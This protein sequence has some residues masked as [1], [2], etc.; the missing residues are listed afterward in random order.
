MVRSTRRSRRWPEHWIGATLASARICA[1]LGCFLLGALCVQAAAQEIIRF[2]A[3]GQVPPGYPAQYGAI[4]AAAE[5]EGQLVIHSTTDSRIA[6]PLID[7]FQTLYPRIEVRYQDMNSNDLHNVYLG[8]CSPVPRRRMSSGAPRWICSCSWRAPDR[9]RSTTR[10]RSLASRR[11][12]CGRT[13]RSAQRSSRSPSST[14]SDLSL[15]TRFRSRIAIWHACSP[16]SAT[17][18]PARS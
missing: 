3:K 8:T 11:G 13:W 9:R 18:S 12:P 17:D 14:T 7:D 15:R 4:V 2:P 5:Q 1:S 6:A 16:T 10:P